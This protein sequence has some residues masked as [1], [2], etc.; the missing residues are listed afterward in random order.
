MLDKAASTEHE[1][2]RDAFFAKA[3]ALI[4][5]HHIEDSE[6]NRAT[7]KMEEHPVEVDGWGNAIRGVVHLYTGVGQINQC[8]VAHRTGRGYSRVIIWGSE[9]DAKLTCTL[10]DYLLPQLRAD[11][12]R[13]RPRSR[14]SYAVGWAIEVIDRLSEAQEAE[15]ASTN[16]LIPTNTEA[17]EALRATYK[18]RNSRR[19]EVRPEEF[20]QGVT[21]GGSADIGITKLGDDSANAELG[22]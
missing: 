20:D 2:E 19:A 3:Q 9:I 16:A 6:L 18:L 17:D 14:M 7:S 22:A 13:D 5:R 4:T 10:V 8:S 21:A 12:L 11:I 15:A 1:P